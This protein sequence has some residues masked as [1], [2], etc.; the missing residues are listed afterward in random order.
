MKKIIN[1]L[2]ISN[3]NINNENQTNNI[4]NLKL[5][6]INS[7][8]SYRKTKYMNIDEYK[9]KDTKYIIEYYDKKQFL[10]FLKNKP[11]SDEGI[12]QK[13]EEPKG[14][15]NTIYRLTWSPKISIFEKCSNLKKLNDKHFDIYERAVTYDGEEF[16]TKKEPVK[17]THIPHGMQSIATRISN[18]VSNITLEKIKIVRM[19]LNFKVD[20]KD[21]IIF[22]WCSSLRIDPG[23]NKKNLLNKR[24]KSFSGGNSNRNIPE[25]RIKSVD[26]SKLKFFHPDNI[27]IFKY[28][29]LGRPIEP[30]KEGYCPNCGLNVENYKLYEINFKNLIESNENLKRDNQYFQLYDN[31]NMTSNGIEVI[32]PG[33]KYNKNSINK[34]ILKQLKYYNYKN[35][36]IPKVIYELFPELTINDYNSLKKDIVFLNKKTFVCDICFLE[37]TKYCSMA[38]SNNLNLLKGKTREENIINDINEYNKYFIRPKSAFKFNMDKIMNKNDV[39]PLLSKRKLKSIVQRANSFQ[40]IKNKSKNNLYQNYISN[41]KIND[42][43]NI[44]NA[45]IQSYNDNKTDESNLDNNE[46]KH[47]RKKVN[48]NKFN[49]KKN[50]TFNR[51]N[52]L[53]KEN[54]KEINKYFLKNKNKIS[55]YAKYFNNIKNLKENTN[56]LKNEYNNRMFNSNIE[57]NKIFP[58]K[59]QKINIDSNK[60]HL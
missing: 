10:E 48:K 33:D 13:F 5:S 22:L 11:K 60:S 18:H 32:S 47:I 16:Q 30:H 34:N 24:N 9:I 40:S 51:L 8:Y 12:L 54:N 53:S 35:F 14:D 7:D 55:N 27:N 38:G 17:G 37:I 46:K 4:I 41:I 43:N 59:I 15:Y 52:Y 29:I 6:R 39:T 28:S 20:K 19:I 23:I 49:F 31:I 57:N 1:N 56:R 50:I 36:V 42:K 45:Y 44:K 58:V 25:T 21:R 3:S 2:D 26:D